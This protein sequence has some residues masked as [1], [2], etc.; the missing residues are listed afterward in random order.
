MCRAGVSA[1]GRTARLTGLP[2][3][4]PMVLLGIAAGLIVAAETTALLWSAK[5]LD[6]QAP[7]LAA[8][9]GAGAAFF[10]ICNAVVRVQGDRL[11]ARYGDLPLM[12]ASLVVA[13]AGFAAFGFSHSFAA[14]VVSFAVIGLGTAVLVPCAIALAANHVPGNRTAGISFISAMSAVPRI[15]APWA[16]GWVVSASGFN[17]AF[18]LFAGVLAVALVL[19]VVLQNLRG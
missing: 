5:L 19:I 17:M 7:E 10:G 6:A 18:S 2:N 9:A 4:T 1:G 12:M 16:F 13:T 3:K 15:A 11:R 14:S 8:V